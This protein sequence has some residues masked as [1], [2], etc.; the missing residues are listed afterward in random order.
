[1]GHL[2]KNKNLEIQ[3]D[4]PSENYSI[5]D[6]TEIDITIAPNQTQV[7]SNV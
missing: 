2:L 7:L 6:L 4:F 3:I 5:Y 1:M